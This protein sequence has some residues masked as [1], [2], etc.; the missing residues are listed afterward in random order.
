MPQWF[1]HIGAP[2]ITQTSKVS[3]QCENAH[4]NFK[5]RLYLKPEVIR[6][7]GLN[8]GDDHFQVGSTVKKRARLP[9]EIGRMAIDVAE[10]AI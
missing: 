2:S 9:L 3:Q 6:G 10:N 5:K 1:V 8:I 7:R 4:S